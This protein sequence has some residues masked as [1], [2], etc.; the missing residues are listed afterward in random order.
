MYAQYINSSIKS[1]DFFTLNIA[2]QRKLYTEK[3][4]VRSSDIF[5]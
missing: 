3:K 5:F 1:H 4:K 2:I